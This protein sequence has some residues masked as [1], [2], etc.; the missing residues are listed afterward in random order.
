M[1]KQWILIMAMMMS[2]LV[3]AQH[4]G[5]VTQGE[6]RV[7][8]MKTELSLNDTQ[9]EAIKAINAKYQA[10]HALLRKDSIQ[11]PE[12][13]LAATRSLKADQNNEISA[14]LTPE[15]QTKWKALKA[16]HRK[17]GK[18]HARNANQTYRERL[19]A[20]LS[21]TDEQFEKINAANKGLREKMRALKADNAADNGKWK[22]E[23]AKAR[24]E[25]D[26]AIKAVLS[27]E[28]YEKWTERRQEM[29]R[30]QH[31]RRG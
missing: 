2:T 6:G 17:S 23:A 3:F 15:Q 19:K 12:Q 24:A 13:R 29:K 25:H 7:E 18:T 1:K 11:S 21:L 16:E 30:A 28:Q 14:L 22:A 9:Y 10:K 8:K 5:P 4:K 27:P 31:H 20:D 26:E